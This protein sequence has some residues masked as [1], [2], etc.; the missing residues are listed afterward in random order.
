MA[1]FLEALIGGLMAGM[2]YALV[3]VG[4][5]LIYKASGIFNFAQGS[6]VLFAAL[7][8]ARLLEWLPRS[9]HLRSAA[10]SIL[11][12][13]SLTLLLLAAVCWM[14]QRLCFSRLA[15]RG[16][17]PMLMA[18]IGIAYILDGVG[19]LVFGSD[20]YKIDVGMPKAPLLL[21]ESA[22]PGGLLVSREDLVATGLSIALVLGLTAFFQF[23][24]AGLA[25][26]AVADDQR[27][28]L[29]LGISLEKTWLLAWFVSSV[30]A[31]C[32]GVVWGSKLGVQFAL[33]QIALKA[34]PA[35]VLGGLTSIPG[36]IVGALLIGVG[37]KLSESFIGPIIG[38]GIETWFA[39]VLALLLLLVRPEGLLGEKALVRV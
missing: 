24:R 8:M 14:I 12:S 20:I 19:Q 33:S 35:V 15:S 13:L 37:E 5:V 9:L 7:A 32:A 6:M 28:S 29:S 17:V 25:L 16:A 36:A 30:V 1:F 22:F 18:T 3:A 39:Y 26:R 23:T 10:L 21:L 4:F 34:L 27:A 31:L 38:G 11:L 2:L